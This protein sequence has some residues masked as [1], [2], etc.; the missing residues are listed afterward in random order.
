MSVL[1]PSDVLEMINHQQ[2][3]RQ[4]VE[5]TR[6]AVT[7]QKSISTLLSL[8][9]EL[10]SYSARNRAFAEKIRQASELRR[11]SAP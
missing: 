11:A 8:S 4:R 1:S 6:Q 3:L 2:D 5:A 9:E 10:R 7:S